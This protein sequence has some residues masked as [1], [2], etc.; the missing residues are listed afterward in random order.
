V[1]PDTAD[2]PVGAAGQVAAARPEND[3]GYQAVVKTLGRS[4]SRL[5]TPPKDPVAKRE[6]IRAAAELP[7]ARVKEEKAYHSNLKEME[8]APLPTIQDFSVDEF[9]AAFQH[10]FEELAKQLPKQSEDNHAVSNAVDFGPEKAVAR[11]KM[12]SEKDDRS[13][14]LRTASSRKPMDIAAGIPAPPATPELAGDPAGPVP[15]IPDAA[16]AAPKPLPAKDVSL[17][18]QSKAL[19]DSLKNQV[20]GGQ[21]LNIDEASLPFEASGEK[22]FDD[23]LE[24]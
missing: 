21:V 3:A 24:T 9:M 16:A 14:A 17:D 10:G 20:A 15:A 12:T 23:A 22:S 2:V 11:G 6:E 5:K 4:A 13:K 7:A 8:E 1:P 18:D 19:D